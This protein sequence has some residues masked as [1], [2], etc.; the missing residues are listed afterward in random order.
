ME[1]SGPAWCESSSEGKQVPEGRGGR[2]CCCSW[3]HLCLCHVFQGTPA[4][5]CTE[6]GRAGLTKGRLAS[7]E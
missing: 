7:E 6:L 2:F 5:S 3:L 4:Q 1:I